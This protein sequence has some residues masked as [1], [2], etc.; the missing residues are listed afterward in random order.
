MNTNRILFI[1]AIAASLSLSAISAEAARKATNA[2]KTTKVESSKKQTKAESEK[3]INPTPAFYD[4]IWEKY[5]I[6]K[7]EDQAEVIK[8]LKKVIKTMPDEY[9]AHYYL[10][11]MS[12]E[13]GLHNQALNYFEIALAGFP[14]SADIH[15]RMAQILDEKNKTDEADEH[16]KLALALD[17]SNPTA[18]ARVGIAE[19]KA[20]NFSKAESYLKKAREIEPDK[21]STLKALGE[22]WIE[23]GNYVGAIE[24]L[25]QAILFDEKDASTCMLLGKAYEAN[26]N[27][28]KAADYIALASQYGKKDAELIEEIG[29]GLARNLAKS[30]KNEEA[31]AAYK[32]EINQNNDKGQGYYELGQVYEELE[33]IDSAI[34]SYKKA[35]EASK[36]MTNAIFRCAE[37]YHQQGDKDNLEKMVKIIRN[38][39]EFKD[40]AESMLEDL[41]RDQ[42]L[43]A[44]QE[45]QDKLTSKDTKDGDLEE[46]YKEVY[47]HNKKDAETLE[48]LYN[49]YKDRGYYDEALTWY[50]RYAKVA[51]VSDYDKKST[52][53]ELK[54][55]LEQDNYYLYGGKKEETPGKSKVSSDDLLNQAFNGEND[56][57]KEHSF[58]IL[59]TRKDY[60]EDRKILEGAVKFYEERGKKKEASK[61]INQ[62]K[63][64][65]YISDSEAKSWKDRL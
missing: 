9:M 39:P 13:S 57:I 37:L 8:T 35:F 38:N 5:K 27:H 61:Y 33:D 56:R 16:Y 40:K 47:E 32:K 19:M 64:L 11:I 14:K 6:G 43:Q 26:G 20:K 65:G 7:E 48:N 15:I 51:S 55:H 23:T 10:G 53:Q 52:E 22:V 3:Q 28:D 25:E 58:K 17:E 2:K 54:A 36:K 45:L 46:A 31:V 29:Y 63:K 49:Y 34:K 41:K 12:T 24:I 21:L 62:M 60:K 44:E 1:S 30:G 59:L 4:K 50:R 42:E 18:L